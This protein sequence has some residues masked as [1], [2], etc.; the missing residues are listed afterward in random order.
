MNL[1]K[2]HCIWAILLA[3]SI[4]KK[5]Y[6]LAPCC[7]DDINFI[8][9]W[10]FYSSWLF[11]FQTH[12]S[13]SFSLVIIDMKSRRVGQLTT[14]W[15]QLALK[16]KMIKHYHSGQNVGHLQMVLKTLMHQLQSL[17]FLPKLNKAIGQFSTLKWSKSW[18]S[19]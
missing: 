11:M 1:P 4:I 6:N 15:W 19:L 5:E 10:Y 9:F 13:L 17:L 16:Q 2:Y 7:D 12:V 3:L 8:S 18:R 14:F